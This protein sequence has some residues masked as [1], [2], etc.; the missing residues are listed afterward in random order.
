M[1]KKRLIALLILSTVMVNNCVQGVSTAHAEEL[2]S[3]VEDLQNEYLPDDPD[4]NAGYNSEI[5]VDKNSNKKVSVSSFNNSI[6]WV[7]G[8]Y[9]WPNNDVTMVLGSGITVYAL[10]YTTS[11][12]FY[13]ASKKGYGFTNTSVPNLSSLEIVG[14]DSNGLT[15]MGTFP[16]YGQTQ[17]KLSS[18][19]STSLV[20]ENFGSINYTAELIRCESDT[21]EKDGC[22]KNKQST[23]YSPYSI[24]STNCSNGYT[25]TSNNVYCYKINANK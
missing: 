23:C 11:G 6:T 1:N 14:G 7:A 17:W 9:V 22:Y 12:K 25:A 15:I 20:T 13:V 24:A 4:P 10:T 16:Q 2:T 18:S 3:T 5:I 8:T 21:E 19:T